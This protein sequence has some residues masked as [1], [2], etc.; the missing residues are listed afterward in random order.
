MPTSDT[1]SNPLKKRTMAETT[2]EGSRVSKPRGRDG[3]RPGSS[4]SAGLR[5]AADFVR[6]VTSGFFLRVLI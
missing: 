5:A 6:L 3:A 2:R 4:R 1:V